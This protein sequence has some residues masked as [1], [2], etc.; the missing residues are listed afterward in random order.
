V[1]STL[2]RLVLFFHTGTALIFPKQPFSPGS[3]YLHFYM[4]VKCDRPLF[5]NI[6]S[7]FLYVGSSYLNHALSFLSYVSGNIRGE[8]NE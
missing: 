5:I 3:L 4:Q 6:D 8:S 7:R 1:L 2:G